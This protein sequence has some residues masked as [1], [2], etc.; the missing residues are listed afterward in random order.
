M[1]PARVAA[2]L[3]AL[4]AS[5]GLTASVSAEPPASPAAGERAFQKCYACHSVDPAEKGAEGPLLQGVVGRKVAALPG[6][7]YSAAMRAY[8]ADGKRWT[9]ER[10]DAFI[11]HP[12]EVVAHTAMG[13]FGM[14]DP[15]ERKALIAWLAEQ[16]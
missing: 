12:Q 3:G 7:P 10:L 15:A 5:A 8:G 13:F 6:Y 14:P 9:R 2:A 4:H 1:R 16:R 11:A